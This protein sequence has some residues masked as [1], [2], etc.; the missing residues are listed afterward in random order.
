MTMEVYSESF[1]INSVALRTF[2]GPLIHKRETT[3]IWIFVRSYFGTN[4][5]LTS[6]IG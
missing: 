4:D 1:R 2:R 3:K 5:P 6:S